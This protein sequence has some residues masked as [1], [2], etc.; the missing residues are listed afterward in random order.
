MTRLVTE[1]GTIHLFLYNGSQ[2]QQFSA[3]AAVPPA[4]LSQQESCQRSYGGRHTL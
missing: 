2:L 4:H 3:S 1:L